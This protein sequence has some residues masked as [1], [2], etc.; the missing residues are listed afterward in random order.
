MVL[1]LKTQ[2]PQLNADSTVQHEGIVILVE[3]RV[4]G[5]AVMVHQHLDGSVHLRCCNRSLNY[6][7]VPYRPRKMKPTV[8]PAS[9]KITRHRPAAEHPWRG[10]YKRPRLEIHPRA[11]IPSTR[12]GCYF[13]TAISK[14]LEWP[15]APRKP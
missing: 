6:R 7:P 14:S 1:C 10:S 3:D 8:K 11:P 13:A 12:Q 2:R 5:Q 9:G 15:R 4:R